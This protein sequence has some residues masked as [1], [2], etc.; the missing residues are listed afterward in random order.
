[1]IQFYSHD[2]FVPKSSALKMSWMLENGQ[3]QAKW[4]TRTPELIKPDLSKRTPKPEQRAR[5]SITRAA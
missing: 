4:T 1:M 2:A 5:R 3:L